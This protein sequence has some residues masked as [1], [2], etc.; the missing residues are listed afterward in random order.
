MNSIILP[1]DCI[2]LIG[3]FDPSKI[4]QGD[5]LQ[6][7]ADSYYFFKRNFSSGNPLFYDFTNPYSQ[8]AD[9]KSK[10]LFYTRRENRV[11]FDRNDLAF[12]SD[13]NPGIAI[14]Y[15]RLPKDER[16][17]L[18]PDFMIECLTAFVVMTVMKRDMLLSVRGKKQANMPQIR[19]MSQEL[20]FDYKTKAKQAM[21]RQINIIGTGEEVIPV[22]LHV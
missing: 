10:G 9:F 20:K 12:T 6:K 13:T 11:F 15:T 22:T 5:I 4:T 16:G 7:E 3:A 14:L 1:E 21:V 17:D 8:E 19:M 18:V 2:G